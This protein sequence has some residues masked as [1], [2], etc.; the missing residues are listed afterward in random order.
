MAVD[1]AR[2]LRAAM[3]NALG[4]HVIASVQHDD[5]TWEHLPCRDA[6][7]L[8]HAAAC[9]VS[10]ERLRQLRVTFLEGRGADAVVWVMISASGEIGARSFAVSELN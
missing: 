1:Y 10:S 8:A 9:G 4:E 5:G 2:R 3:P 6:S 7:F